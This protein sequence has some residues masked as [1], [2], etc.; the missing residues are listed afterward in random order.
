[1]ADATEIAT[2][3]EQ[4]V[5]ATDPNVIASELA[6]AIKPLLESLDTSELD[7]RHQIGVILKTRL[8]PDGQKRLA[9]GG[10]VME[11]LALEL[12]ISRSNLNRMCQFASQF[13]TV[14]EFTAKHPD[15]KTWSKV[16]EVLV[17]RG[18]ATAHSVDLT[19]THLQQCAR[20]LASYLGRFNKSFNSSYANLLGECQRAAQQL[21]EVFQKHLS[22]SSTVVLNGPDTEPS[23]VESSA[24]EGDTPLES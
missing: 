18:T 2:A 7:R 1:M 11:K 15:A 14:A 6:A 5:Q 21:A 10:K 3:V 23:S 12:N 22:P 4:V 16:K 9:Y 13:L 20:S 19:R 17:K 24:A 8:K